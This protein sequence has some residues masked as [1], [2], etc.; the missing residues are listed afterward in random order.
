MR[1]GQPARGRP[2]GG[3]PQDRGGEGLPPPEVRMV[4]VGPGVPQV[5]GRAL[6]RARDS[7]LGRARPA[8]A[9]GLGPRVPGGAAER[10]PPRPGEARGGRPGGGGAADKEVRHAAREGEE[11]HRDGE[12][13]RGDRGWA[14]RQG[15]AALGAGHRGGDRR[16]HPALRV[17]PPRVAGQQARGEGPLEV[18]DGGEGRVRGL[19]RIGRGGA[20]RGPLLVQAAPRGA[21]ERGQ[22]LL[23]AREAQVRGVPPLRRLPL[24]GEEAPDLPNELREHLL[25]PPAYH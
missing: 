4:P 8:L 7:R 12:G 6:E 11:D 22:G 21:G 25:D 1:D 17:Q 9:L 23:R 18:R 10:G 5:V 19:A 2:A 14:V 3:P 24:L 16:Q 20:A 15:E 13:L